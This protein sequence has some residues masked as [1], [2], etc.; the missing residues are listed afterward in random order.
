MSNG[1]RER[2]EIWHTGSLGD[3]DDARTLNSAEKARDTTCD[4]EK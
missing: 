2:R 4:D 1:G 3:E